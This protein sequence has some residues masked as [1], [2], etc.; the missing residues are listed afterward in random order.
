MDGYGWL[1]IAID[2]YGCCEWLTM[3]MVEHD[4]G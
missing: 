3:T 1:W 2:R 4:N